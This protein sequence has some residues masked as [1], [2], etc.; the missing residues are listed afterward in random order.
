KTDLCTTP[1][2]FGKWCLFQCH[3]LDDVAC[4]QN[5]DCFNG[6]AAG[7]FGPQCQY[8]SSEIKVTIEGRESDVL[9]DNNVETCVGNGTTFLNVSLL[10]PQMFTWMRVNMDNIG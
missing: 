7:W 4:D 1:G 5:G 6:C 8:K 2:W 10:F 3:C 9:T